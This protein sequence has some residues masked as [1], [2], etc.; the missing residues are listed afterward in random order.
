M[1]SKEKLSFLALTLEADDSNSWLDLVERIDQFVLKPKLFL[2]FKLTNKPNVGTFCAVPSSSEFEQSQF[3]LT[4]I[5]QWCAD[6]LLVRLPY[7]RGR[8]MRS[9][10]SPLSLARW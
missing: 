9:S 10:S 6:S 4:T 2:D 1:E 5:T 3:L 7:L 8:A